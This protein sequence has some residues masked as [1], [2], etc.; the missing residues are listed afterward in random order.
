MSSHS[1]KRQQKSEV[2][3]G[4][5]GLLLISCIWGIFYHSYSH[6]NDVMTTSRDIEVLVIGK[7]RGA[8]KSNPRTVYIRDGAAPIGVVTSGRWYFE[9]VV[10]QKTI[11]KYSARYHEYRQ[12]YHRTGS[13]KFMLWY[14]GIIH[15]AITARIIWLI[16]Y[17][18][19]NKNKSGS[20]EAEPDQRAIL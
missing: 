19:F 16:S 12:P 3:A 7:K 11:V 9:T 17:L 4:L 14:I 1:E 8:V 18:W 13:K 6:D 15:L 20:V 5:L 2:F 10:G